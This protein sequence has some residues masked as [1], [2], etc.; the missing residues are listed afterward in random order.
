MERL[1]GDLADH[2]VFSITLVGLLVAD[3]VARFPRIVS[4]TSENLLTNSD[5]GNIV[6]F[7]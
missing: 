7:N 5:H 2:D 3:F 1:N 6:E 4:V